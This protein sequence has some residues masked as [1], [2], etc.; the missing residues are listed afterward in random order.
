MNQI[1]INP[2]D[3]SP[4]AKQAVLDRINQQIV[5]QGQCLLTARKTN[6]SGYLQ[7]RVIIPT[8]GPPGK[9]LLAH[10]L[11]YA[12]STGQPIGA[13]Y[14]P[15]LQ[16]SHRCGNNRCMAVGHLTLEP[17]AIN[18]GRYPCFSSGQC[19][20]NHRSDDGVTVFPDCII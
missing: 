12:F 18:M 2:A 1:D 5:H 13:S 20:G 8:I 14:T 10:R 11:V 4:A 15:G 7:L 9:L 6:T 16:V 19:N 17:Q 3:F